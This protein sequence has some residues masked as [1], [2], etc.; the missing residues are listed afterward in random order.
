MGRDH[1]SLLFI[2]VNNVNQ[3][4]QPTSRSNASTNTVLQ[5]SNPFEL[6]DDQL[7]FADINTTYQP[8]DMMDASAS[9]D[10]VVPA[11]PVAGVAA[12][13]GARVAPAPA[14]V[15]AAAPLLQFTGEWCNGLHSTNSADCRCCSCVRP[16]ALPK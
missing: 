12:A 4:A 3:A 5:A 13:A 11:V 6:G 14:A 1:R 7:E 2:G 15:P 10:A 9:V 8:P 16:D